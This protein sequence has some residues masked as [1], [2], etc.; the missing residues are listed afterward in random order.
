M[1]GTRLRWTAPLVVG[2]AVGALLVLR[3]LGPYAADLPPWLV[4]AVAGTALTLVGIT[5]ESRLNNLRD[6]GQYISRLR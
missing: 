5:W 6:A 4:I 1:A 2:G 3:E